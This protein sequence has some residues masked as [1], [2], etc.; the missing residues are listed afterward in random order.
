MKSI[1][2][3]TVKLSCF[4]FLFL[5]SLFI[6]GQNIQLD[7]DFGNKFSSYKDLQDF[8]NQDALKNSKIC[9]VQSYG[10][11][12]EGRLMQLVFFGN[13]TNIANLENIRTQHLIR[14]GLIEGRTDQSKVPP[15]IW[16]SFNVH[17][18]EASSTE[19]SMKLMQFLFSDEAKIYLDKLLIVIDPCLNPDGR[20]RYVNWY[21]EVSGEKPNPNPEALEHHEPWPGGRYNHYLA[22]LNRDWL[23]QVQDESKQRLAAFHKWMPEVH[24]DFHE[25]D[26]ETSYFFPPAAEPLHKQVTGWQKEAHRIFGAAIRRNFDKQ[27]WDYYTR[28]EYDLLYPG[29]GDSYSIFNGSIGFTLEQAGSAHAGLLYIQQTGDTLRLQDRLSHHYY[30]A[31]GILEASL[32]TATKLKENQQKYFTETADKGTGKYKGYLLKRKNNEDKIKNLCDLLDGLQLSYKQCK[33]DMKSTAFDFELQKTA[34]TNIDKGD[35]FIPLNQPKGKLADV[36]FEPQTYISDSNTYDIT[37]WALPYVYNIQAFGLSIIPD[38]EKFEVNNRYS[39]TSSESVYAWITPW[40]NI[41]DAR[42]LSELLQQ[43]ILVEIHPG[44]L[45]M[46]NIE[47]EKGVL[48]IRNKGNSEVIQQIAEKCKIEL[49]PLE[50]GLSL[51]SFDLGTE[52]L[53]FIKSPKVAMLIG[54][55]IRAS[56]VGEIWYFFEK[57]LNYPITLIDVDYYGKIDPWMYQMIILPD[58]KYENLNIEKNTI[59]RWVKD[60][61]KLLLMEQA[62]EFLKGFEEYALKSK[63]IMKESDKPVFDYEEKKAEFLKYSVSGNIF[64]V[65]I[66]NSHPLGYGYGDH[67][68]SL[69]RQIPEYEYMK[70]GYNVGYINDSAYV[71]GAIGP[72]AK[73]QSKDALIFGCKDVDKGKIIYMATSPIFRGF[74]QDGKLLM[75]NALFMVN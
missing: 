14:N 20:E 59:L 31:L 70:S 25:M 47:F 55:H 60:G 13:E 41:K 62:I 73:K 27:N 40:G 49:F 12:T 50:S 71:A 29:Y 8:L 53:K 44:A 69:L 5:V 28:E 38:L 68:Y 16:L 42:F 23:W 46:E 17:G 34:A 51:T 32:A 21:K 7:T 11:T 52:K 30:S 9:K 75:A 4:L 58:G 22:D 64:K 63:S 33:T 66:D 24:A 39:K 43:K 19:T 3:K 56:A 26:A 35:L 15:I 36:L 74:W 2:R 57:E 1:F 67:T 18:N 37:A 10:S 61:G 6:K 72:E 48:V 65:K 54:E 45:K